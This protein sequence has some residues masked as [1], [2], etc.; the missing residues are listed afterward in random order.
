LKKKKKK[1]MTLRQIILKIFYPFLMKRSKSGPLGIVLK[2]EKQIFPSHSF[3]ELKTVTNGGKDFNFSDLK[4]KKV[5]IVNTASD[6]GFTGQ[7]SDLQKLHVDYPQLV[8]L[9]FPAND[10]KQ[11][12]KLD[13]YKIAEFCQVNFGVTFPL[14]KKSSVIKGPEQ[15]PIFK[16][17]NDASLNGWNDH[18]TDWNFGK[19]LVNEQGLLTHYFA[20]GITPLSDEM[21]NEIKK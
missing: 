16:W 11:Q 20:A 3:Y 1:E 19:Y 7:F 12:E 14:M 10:F 8:I 18:A 9:G 6:C 4:G 21:V 5:L 15:N 13:D 17:L 2:N